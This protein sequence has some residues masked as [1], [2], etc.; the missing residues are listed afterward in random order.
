MPLETTVPIEVVSL[1]ESLDVVSI[2]PLASG[3]GSR[4]YYRIVCKD[5]SYVACNNLNEAE[6]ADFLALSHLLR[7]LDIPVPTIIEV[8]KS[9]RAYL[10]TDL[11]DTT[12]LQKLIPD[13][14]KDEAWKLASYF[15]CL[16]LL[17]KTQVSASKSKDIMHL[18]VEK[19]FDRIGISLDLHYFKY[20]FLDLNVI[21]YNVR[22]LYL[23]FE[24]VSDML[25]ESPYRGFMYRDF[26]A[27]N[28][29]LD[30]NDDP[31]L[32][33]YQGAML[34]P[35][36]Y[37]LVSLLWQ[38][39][40]NLTASLKNTLKAHY[41]KKL[42]QELSEPID[43]LTFERNYEICCLLR[44]LQV[45]GAYGRRGTI[46]RKQHFL[47]SI[48]FALRQLKEF[49]ET[50]SLLDDFPT[51]RQIVRD[52][53]QAAFI[54]KFEPATFQNAG[55]LRISIKSFSYR[56]GIP[57]TKSVNGGGFVF[58]M[59]GILNP[60][61]FD[62][63]KH[64]SGLDEPVKNFLQTETSMP[65]FLSHIWNLVSISIENYLERGFED[66]SIYFGCTGGQHRSVYAA[67]ATAAFLMNKYPVQTDIEHTNADNWM[68]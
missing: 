16:D 10:M 3:G 11:G 26:Q 34:G 41:Q 62:S 24:K 65:T 32:I 1:I 39:K 20:Y 68:R 61:R 25:S 5:N 67:E 43:E 6:N 14:Q 18:I 29:M 2:Y 50:S 51:L 48:P 55:P 30:S 46:E 13:K 56:K 33:D 53:T 66:L 58:D 35:W 57:I 19:P 42:S 63:Y 44:L 64:L 47:D 45:L 17:C 8:H 49:M 37:D 40:A 12:L 9:K 4:K 7:E 59:R 21:S 22:S 52:I 27:R 15:K 31:W 36:A 23:E 54:Q 28:I 60:G 38:A